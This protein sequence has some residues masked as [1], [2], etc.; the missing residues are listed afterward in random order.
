MYVALNISS[1]DI[2]ILSLKGRKV[3]T[4]AS[5]DLADGLVQD[6]LILQPQGV[7]EAINRLFKSTG[8]PRNNVI[9]SIAGL[10]FTYRFITLPKMKSKLITEAILRA[11][12]KEISLPLD[13]LYVSWQPMPSKGEEQDYFIIG[14]PRNLVDAAVQSLKIAG[15]E[16]YLMDVRPL[17][18]AR[19]ANR[20]NAIVVNMEPDCFDIVFITQGLPS[21]IHTISPRGE[22][23]TLEDNIHRLAD[24]LTKT[25]AFYQSNHPDI[26]LNG[27]LPL[28]LTGEMATDTA[29][30]QM[31]QSEVEYE[32]EPLVPSVEFPDKLPLTSYTTSIGLAAKRTPLKSSGSGEARFFDIN[33]NVLEGKYRKPKAKPINVSNLVWAT[34]LVAVLACIF[35]LYQASSQAATENSALEN[36]LNILD[37]ELNL[38]ALINE[39][40]LI[41]QGIISETQTAADILETA[42]KNLFSTRGVFN[43]RL[44]QVTADIPINTSF[45][46]IEIQKGV[47]IIRGETTD[48]F[49]VIEYATSLEAEGIFNQVRITELD[50]TLISTSA[51][52]EDDSS[53]FQ[54]NVIIF[55]IEAQ[56]SLAE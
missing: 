20:S 46:S 50:E 18:L 6:G 19:A 13:E 3:V 2:K 4:W 28:L 42:N 5:A 11:A 22:G 38:A 25:A 24:E 43:T 8:I 54:V 29:T 12:K 10:S 14:V 40:T 23:A 7:G 27:N 51:T 52:E 41:T 1:H 44:Q 39:E 56:I 37:R 26:H 53:P 16:P 34:L 15:V 36:E 35:P 17:A 33:I 48:L 32:I 31:L 45:T 9:I 49:S 21:V 30:S 55:E 47:I